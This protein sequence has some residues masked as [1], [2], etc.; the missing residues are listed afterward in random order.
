V[1]G[2]SAASNVRHHFIRET[3]IV[4]A[5]VKLT[6]AARLL[7]AVSGGLQ[8]KRFSFEQEVGLHPSLPGTPVGLA[9]R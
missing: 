9:L 4:R 5:N 7:R 8:S 6:G 2:R 1:N 3:P